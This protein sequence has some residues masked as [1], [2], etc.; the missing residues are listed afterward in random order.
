[1]MGLGLLPRLQRQVMVSNDGSS[2][3]EAMEP[4][5]SLDFLKLGWFFMAKAQVALVMVR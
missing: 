2:M 3:M 1:M 4:I 5:L